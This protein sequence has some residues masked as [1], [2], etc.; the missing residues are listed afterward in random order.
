MVKELR[1]QVQLEK[2][3]AEQAEKHLDD[4]LGMSDA[5]VYTHSEFCFVFLHSY[6]ELASLP[7]SYLHSLFR[8][9]K[10]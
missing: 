8:G 9:W 6:T 3:R 1:R 2:K 7:H 10:R 4:I 5:N